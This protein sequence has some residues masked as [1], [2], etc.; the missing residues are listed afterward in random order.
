VSTA[1]EVPADASKATGMDLGKS[2]VVIVIVAVIVVSVL[3]L[4]ASLFF[5][6]KHYRSE[7][8]Q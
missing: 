2:G 5:Y 8:K 7:S 4:L 3:L 1:T 6:Q